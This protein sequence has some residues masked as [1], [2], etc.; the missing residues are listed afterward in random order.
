M[1]LERTLKP[2]GIAVSVP[3][4]DVPNLGES[5]DV[6]GRIQCFCYFVLKFFLLPRMVFF[7]ARTHRGLGSVIIDD[8]RE[9]LHI[10]RS[11]RHG[12]RLR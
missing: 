9:A 7:A 4:G 12:S 6:I 8:E 11:V 2:L 5:T 1:G 10:D 3:S